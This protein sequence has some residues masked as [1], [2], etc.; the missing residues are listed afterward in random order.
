M[1]IQLTADRTSEVDS[2]RSDKNLGSPAYVY[3]AHHVFYVSA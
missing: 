3:K 1:I 2:D